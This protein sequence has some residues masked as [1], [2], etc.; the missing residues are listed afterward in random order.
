MTKK[1]NAYIGKT[2]NK[3]TGK[4]V[5]T[6][7][8]FRG[9]FFGLLDPIGWA[10]DIVGILNVRKLVLYAIILITVG[11]YFYVQGRGTKPVKIDIGYGKEAIL[12]LNKKG[13]YVHIDKDGSVYY[14]NRAGKVLRKLTVSDIPGLKRKLAPI[15]FQLQ[16]IFIGGVGIGDAGAEGEVGVGIS[17]FRYWKMQLEGF[18]S[19]KGIYLGTSYNI[20]DNSGAGLAIGKGYRG[21]DR[22]MLYYRFNF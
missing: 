16:P 5:F 14:K 17:F 20:T 22:V 8:R 10:R 21:D 19:Q 2:Y 13:E 3:K 6:W 1:N 18:L 12:E 4:E 15:G 9:G 11:V 7:R